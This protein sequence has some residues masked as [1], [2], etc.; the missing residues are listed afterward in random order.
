MCHVEEKISMA[1]AH[2][3]RAAHVLFYFLFYFFYRRT[4]HL[5]G[6]HVGLY[7]D[8]SLLCMVLGWVGRWM[9]G[10]VQ[11]FRKMCQSGD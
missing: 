4:Y 7:G 8:K 5:G 1:P 2:G 11:K 10:G 6:R 9:G 3:L